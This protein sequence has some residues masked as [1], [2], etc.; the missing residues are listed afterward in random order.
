MKIDSKPT[1]L[2]Q[3]LNPARMITS[4]WKHRDLARQLAL[5]DLA[6]RCRSSVGGILLAV[7]GPLILLAV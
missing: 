7:G 6:C 2:R 5:R 3:E 4:L 1:L